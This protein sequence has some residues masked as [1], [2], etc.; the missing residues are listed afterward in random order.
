MELR[1]IYTARSIISNKPSTSPTTHNHAIQ[2]LRYKNCVAISDQMH[3]HHSSPLFLKQRFQIRS[4]TSSKSKLNAAEVKQAIRNLL[5]YFPPETHRQLGQEFL[6]ELKTYGHVYM[7]HFL[8]SYSVKAYPIDAYP[9]MN[10][11]ARAIQLMIMNN[12]DPDVA[13]FPQELITYGGNGSV[14]QNWA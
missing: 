10:V 11:H 5:R 3:S 6:E 7:Y 2:R 13:Q 12:L 4:R 8:P 9:A 14:F 1:K